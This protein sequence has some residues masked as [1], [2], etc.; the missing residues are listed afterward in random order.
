MGGVGS[1][2]CGFLS[3]CLPT[4]SSSSPSLPLGFLLAHRLV[5]LVGG[6]AGMGGA[7]GA[8]RSALVENDMRLRAGEKANGCS[9]SSS[10]S[11]FAWMRRG[12]SSSSSVT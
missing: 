2:S 12:R 3:L 5:S 9:A 10:G 6:T 1:I 7:K 8:S 11:P 4:L